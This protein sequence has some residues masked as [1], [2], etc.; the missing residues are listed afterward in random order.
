MADI[1][2]LQRVVRFGEFEAELEAGRLYRRGAKVR[3]REQSFLVLSMLL[4]HAGEVVTREQLQKRLWPG[5]TL[6]DV[7]VNLNTAIARLREALGD[8]A[9][10]PR[11]IETLPKRGYRF[12]AAA[13]ESPA[14]EPTAQRRIRLVMLPLLNVDG[15]PAE[16]YFSDAVTDE[17]ITALCQIAPA[18]LA[19]IARTTSMHYKHSDKPVARIGRELGVDYVVEGGVRR[20]EDRVAMS[21]QLIHATDQTHGFARRYEGESGDIF[22]MVS[23]AAADIAHSI[24]IAGQPRDG[25]AGLAIG[26]AS[27]RRPTE[28]LAAYNEYIQGR[29]HMAKG[30]AAGFAAATEHLERA[31]TRDP[32]FALAYDALAEIHWYLGYFG[33]VPPRK[34]FSAGI[35]HALRAVEIDN[36]RAET[37]ALLGEFHKTLEYNWPEVER[38]MALA[39]RLDPISPLVRLRHA[40]S[41]LMPHGHIEEAIVEIRLALEMDPMSLLLQGLLGVMLVLAHRWDLALEQGRLL[42]KLYPGAFWGHFVR[43]VAFRGRR[44]FEASA[45]AFRAALE[46]SP[47]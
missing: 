21:V 17:I 19:V 20:T 24:G 37:H 15:D 27:R 13:S 36:D 43:G 1:V 40:V 3:L 4:E 35:V 32:D 16:E 45:A 31:V 25:R 44:M 9:E 39:L 33:Y 12:L 7:D 42:L 10:H 18:R 26:G 47:P 30:S 41:N 11:Y 8:S 6:V 34:A 23:R 29:Y 38:E 22:G 14:L 28:D 5:D 46:V 2:S